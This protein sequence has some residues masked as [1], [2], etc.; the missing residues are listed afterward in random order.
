MEIGRR[1]LLT[2]T[3]AASQVAL[4]GRFGLWSRPAKAAGDGSFPTKILCVYV[5]GGLSHE[6]MWA[7]FANADVP[8]YVPRYDEGG[9]DASHYTN[10]DG[11]G[12]ADADAVIRRLRGPIRWNWGD[13]WNSLPNG[14]ALGY[15]WCAPEY[16]LYERT[17]VIHGVDQGTAAHPSGKVAG[18]C[19]V[20]GANYG[21]PAI[22]AVIANHFAARFP[23]RAVPSV[24]IAAGPAGP[25][26]SLPAL[27]NPTKLHD[28][29]DL[30]YAL[31][32]ERVAWDGFRTRT[33]EPH[34][35]FDG[36]PLD[37][38]V[39]L[40]IVDR[41]AMRATRRFRGASASGT[42]A[43]LE[44]LHDQYKLFSKTIARDVTSTIES[45]PGIEHLPEAMPWTPNEPQLGF[46]YGPADITAGNAAYITEFDLALRLL[47]S[48]MCSAV[49]MKLNTLMDLDTHSTSYELHRDHLRGSMDVLGR[50]IIE[51]SLTPCPGNAS[52]SL[53]DDTL[54]YVFSEFGR[55]FMPAGQGG[56]GSDH[57]PMTSAILVG[58]AVQ[59]NR[60][61]G[62]FRDGNH[63]GEPV[64]LT[65]EG[66]ETATRPPRAQDVAATIY[67]SLGMT[68]DD[69]FIPGGFGTISGIVP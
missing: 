21:A 27:S 12:D 26:V 7:P 66:G 37:G 18:M 22:P 61:V 69:Y 50:L 42:D 1:K 65:E 10:L 30:Q 47:K 48:D 28:I 62:G 39:P 14:S 8:K 59:G 34:V 33:D 64:E 57:N 40:S 52:K 13:D 45:T 68:T 17:A 4:L 25:G 23:D 5:G 46:R 41:A 15:A 31:S 63:T 29:D 38:T 56:T 3:V 2:S 67:A 54:V 51:M 20:A 60:M 32:D 16:G 58:G 11:S 35:G 55:S 6:L 36:E 44:G 24:S 19:G 9:F 43:F 49:T 53:L